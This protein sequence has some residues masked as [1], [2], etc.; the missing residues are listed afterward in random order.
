MSASYLL[1]IYTVTGIAR[2]WGFDFSDPVVG[3]DSSKLFE[4][5]SDEVDEVDVSLK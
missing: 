2:I 4:V 5:R 1:V 3:F